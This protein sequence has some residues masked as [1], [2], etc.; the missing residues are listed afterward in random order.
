MKHRKR[1]FLAILKVELDDL[2]ADIE[3][4]INECNKEHEGGKLTD[5]VCL[6]NLCVF[7]NELLGVDVFAR[8]IDTTDPDQFESLTELKANLKNAFREK[9]RAAGLVPAIVRYVERKMNKVEGYVTRH[10]PDS[11]PT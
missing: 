1:H 7:K 5:Y 6:E 11:V 8:I 9:I 3:Q 10:Q 4:L 2:H